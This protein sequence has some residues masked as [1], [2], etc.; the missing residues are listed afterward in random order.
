VTQSAKAKAEDSEL[1]EG[2]EPR[3][4]LWY[5]YWL[6]FSR[7]LAVHFWPRPLLLIGLV[8][9]VRFRSAGFHKL[10]R[11]SVEVLAPCDYSNGR[12]HRSWP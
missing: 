12:W 7:S 10:R 6:S 5:D 4:Y 2:S 9:A 3:L 11:R 1:A 8:L